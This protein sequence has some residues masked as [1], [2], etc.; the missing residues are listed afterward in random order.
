MLAWG[1]YENGKTLLDPFCRDGTIGITAYCM[2]TGRSPHFYAKAEFPPID[3]VWDHEVPFKGEIICSAPQFGEVKSAEKNAKI[4][5]IKG[6]TFRRVENDWLDLK[7][8]PGSVDCIVSLFP[9]PGA[10]HP[11]R[12]LERTYRDTLKLLV[13][14]L[15]KNGR[16][17]T[18]TNP[19][20]ETVASGVGF[21]L[22][23][24]QE[25]WQGK[26]MLRIGVFGI[27]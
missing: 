8:A 2:A 17:C 9:Q 12:V 6:I 18:L 16:I 22:L 15:K 19:L 20:L 14:I 4:A 27:T 26:L 5:G 24:T 3:P 23:E 25:I 1:E 13:D 10:R 21:K 11:P 7:F